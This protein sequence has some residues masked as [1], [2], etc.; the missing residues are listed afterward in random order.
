MLGLSAWGVKQGHGSFLTFEFGEPKLGVTECK[1]EEI[2]L[3]MSAH[4]HGDRHLWIYCC[5]WRAL[6]DGSQVTW[7][8]N[9][10]ELIERAAARLNGQKLTS[11]EVDPDKGRS[12]FTFDLG[13][14]LET[15]PSGGDS[16]DEQWFIHGKSE[17][18]AY[19]AD[20]LYFLG[21]GDT[22]PADVWWLPMR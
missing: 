5:Y 10:D 3:R 7:S 12:T 16:T 11:V 13:G 1:S 9:A 4:V 14:S 8:E 21:P 18:L 19:G 15:W 2:G 6:Q 20:G 17:V 22:L